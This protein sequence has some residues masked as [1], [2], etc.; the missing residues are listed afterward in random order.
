[1]RTL[2]EIENSLRDDLAAIIPNASTSETAEFRNLA[3]VIAKTIWLYENIQDEFKEYIDEKIDQR[4]AGTIQWYYNEVKKFQGGDD[5]LGNFQADSLTVTEQ[6][7]IEFTTIDESRQIIAVAS[8]SE[9]ADILN[10]KVAKADASGDFE[11]LENDEK[12]AFEYYMK[13]IK[14]PGTALNIV[15]NDPDV[16]KYNITAYYDPFFNKESV[17]ADIESTLEN[18]RK[19]FKFDDK[20]Y[21]QKY[22]DLLMGIEGVK[23]VKIN[24]FQAKEAGGSYSDAD[25]YQ[26]T[27]GYYNHDATS[28]LMLTD[29]ND[30][31]F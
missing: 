18:F 11:P 16:I 24:S 4:H 14:I 20:V 8:L 5:E 12:T 25:A 22:V 29:F 30:L 9:S 2:A 23:S 3:S 13:Q 7:E 28:V 27:A 17:H 26:L 21:K 19:T 31:F 10:I 15:S 1:M 6:G